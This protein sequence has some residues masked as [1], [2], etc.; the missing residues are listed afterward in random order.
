M[1]R[2]QQR[3]QHQ[4]ILQVLLRL[5][6]MLKQRYL[7]SQ[8]K[9]GVHDRIDWIKFFPCYKAVA[10]GDFVQNK[11]VNV[12]RTCIYL[13][14]FFGCNLLDII[15]QTGLKCFNVTLDMRAKRGVTCHGTS[16]EY[17]FLVVFKGPSLPRSYKELSVPCE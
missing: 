8:G 3:Q 12:K 10:S 7:P 2:V 15:F 13:R 6:G 17:S 11:E 9:T 16:S 5:K 1:K 4:I 14:Y